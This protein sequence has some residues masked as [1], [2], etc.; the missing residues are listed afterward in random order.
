MGIVL[1]DSDAVVDVTVSVLDPTLPP[2]AVT[3]TG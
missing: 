3:Q 1:G 2:F